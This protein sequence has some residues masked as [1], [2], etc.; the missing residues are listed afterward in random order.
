M[1]LNVIMVGTAL[2]FNPVL[3]RPLPRVVESSCYCHCRQV[4]PFHPRIFL[5]RAVTPRD[6]LLG[7]SCGESSTNFPNTH[8]DPPSPSLLSFFPAPS[9]IYPISQSEYCVIGKDTLPISASHLCAPLWIPYA[10]VGPA[11]AVCNPICAI[12]CCRIQARHDI[13]LPSPD[14]QMLT[15][16]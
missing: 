10:L 11:I 3:V 12:A 6:A 9:Y 1:P 14:T 13:W 16:L 2:C 5:V 7:P 15:L 8:P 4:S